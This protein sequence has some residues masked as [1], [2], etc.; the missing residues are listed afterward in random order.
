MSGSAGWMRHIIPTMN[1]L[2]GGHRRPDLEK[3]LEEKLDAR[4]LESFYR[5]LQ[6]VEQELMRAKRSVR[7][8]P[9][10]PSLRV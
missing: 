9:G 3:V 7:M 8:W 6:Q 1:T 4:E 5:W 2:A 10:G